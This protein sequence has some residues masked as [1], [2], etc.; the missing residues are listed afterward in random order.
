MN[1][2]DFVWHR[3]YVAGE[4]GLLPEENPYIQRDKAVDEQ[5]A[6]A[7]ES[8]RQAGEAQFFKDAS[9]PNWVTP[10]DSFMLWGCGILGL[11]TLGGG[12][13]LVYSLFF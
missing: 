9:N 11:I 3:G 2:P 4:R 5:K 10:L 8:G 7:W 12:V 13:G 1:K 6:L